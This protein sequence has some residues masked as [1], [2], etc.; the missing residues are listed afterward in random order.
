MASK[1]CK[2]IIF[3]SSIIGAFSGA[4]IVSKKIFDEFSRDSEN[5]VIEDT[6]SILSGFMLG[7]A[8]GSVTIPVIL[9][10]MILYKKFYE[11]ESKDWNEISININ[12]NVPKED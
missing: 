12:I 8:L 7:G 4:G 10:S 2:N 5:N 1:I 11:K 6:A 3:S 9:P